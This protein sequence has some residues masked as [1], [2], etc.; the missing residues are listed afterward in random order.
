[1]ENFKI[2]KYCLY[3]VQLEALKFVSAEGRGKTL[4]TISIKDMEI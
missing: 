2:F 3:A 1:M 4:K